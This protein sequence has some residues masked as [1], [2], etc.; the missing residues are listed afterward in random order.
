M[1][2]IDH[3]VMSKL[4]SVIVRYQNTMSRPEGLFVLDTGILY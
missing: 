4:P 2:H 1:T 3:V